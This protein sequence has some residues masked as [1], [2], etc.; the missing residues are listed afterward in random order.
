MSSLRD[1]FS[2][3]DLLLTDSG[4]TALRLAIGSALDS[5]P[6][7]PVALPAYGC[8]DLA[9]AAVGA[10]VEVLLYDLEPATLGPDLD[11]LERALRLGARAVVIAHLY[12]IPVDAAAVEQM[13]DAFG[14]PLIDDAA[15][16]IGAEHAGRP[17]GSWGSFGVLSFGRGKGVTAGRGGALLVNRRPKDHR[18]TRLPDLARARSG[19]ADLAAGAVQWAF[20]RP[21]LYGLPASM[22]F[23][24]LGETIYKKPVPPG[25]LSRA[26][27]GI[28]GCTLE[29]IDGEVAIRRRNSAVLLDALLGSRSLTAIRPPAAARPSY[30]R[31]PALHPSR[32]LTPRTRRWGVMPGYP[33]PLGQLP[34]VRGRLRNADTEMPGAEHLSRNLMTFPTHGFVTPPDLNRLIDWIASS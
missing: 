4:T 14:V 5:A 2:P 3:D 26:A 24:G 13:C 27:L 30:L 32:S 34:A 16:A 17:P 12:G 6:D 31:L 1:R 19:A 22:P 15:Q 25:R 7:G 28:L 8:Y 10:G 33:L 11:S 21:A 23:L 9:T 18:P 29:Q 20:A